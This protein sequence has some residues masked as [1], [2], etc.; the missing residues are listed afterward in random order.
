LATGA[1]LD[2]NDGA[3]STIRIPVS[4]RSDDIPATM[5]LFHFDT[6]A[7]I[8]RQEGTATLQGTEPNRYYEG[9]VT[10]FTTWN[11]DVLYSS[12]N[13]TGCVVDGN[14]EP[15]AGANVTSEGKDYTGRASVFTDADGNFTVKAKPNSAAF[16]QARKGEAVSNSAEIVTLT[17]DM[18]RSECLVLTQSTVSIKL[19][20][21]GEPND[22]DSHTLAANSDEHIYYVNKGSLTQMPFVALDVDD[23]DGFGPEV[24]TFSRLARSRTYRFYVDNY[25]ETYD[26]GQT[27]SPARIELT[28]GG[29]Q[30][31]F[32]PPTGE[33][34]ATAI[35]HVFDLTTD[36]SCNITVT[37]V[38]QFASQEPSNPNVGND[39]TYC[40]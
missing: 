12:V 3:T 9:T 1:S 38:Q 4:S 35:W 8:W 18:E 32:T 26:P 10:H 14:G 6:E 22:L 24:T 31:V 33:S 7:G 2:L 17:T 39:A 40:D 25:S 16:L 19:T 20:W 29:N 15:V 23:T 13:V 36:D 30:T 21:G 37:P 28:N 34:E 11:A 27:G 5:P